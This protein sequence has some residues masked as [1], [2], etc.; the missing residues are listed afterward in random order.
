MRHL[1]HQLTGTGLLLFHN[2]LG[3]TGSSLVRV[4]VLM[5]L[6][7]L[8]VG[9]EIVLRL[10]DSWRYRCGKSDAK[11]SVAMTPTQG[12]PRVVRLMGVLHWS[13]VGG[14]RICMFLFRLLCWRVTA[15]F[16][17]MFRYDIS[18]TGF[19]PLSVGY[20]QIQPSVWSVQYYLLI[21]PKRSNR[22]GAATMTTKPT[23]P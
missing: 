4:V 23:T 22:S 2:W 15:A 12:S 20:L 19:A 8:V 7:K 3:G 18:T 17:I 6:A 5:A 16:L 13:T 14:P 1:A 11:D 10:N 9:V 21:S